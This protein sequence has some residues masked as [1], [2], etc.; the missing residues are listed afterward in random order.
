MGQTQHTDDRH[1]G[2]SFRRKRTLGRRTHQMMIRE[3]GVDRQHDE[4]FAL[5]SH[6]LLTPLACILGWSQLVQEQDK[7]AT[8]QQA[9]EVIERNARRQ[10]RL[11]DDLLLLFRFTGGQLVLNPRQTDLWRLL[12][13]PTPIHPLPLP[14]NEQLSL[15]LDAPEASL[16]L[17]S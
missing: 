7:P 11:V 2:K 8:V 12:R 1:V 13:P 3:T 9:L 17:S 15:P 16:P 4:F 14:Y 10:K 5:L 6:E